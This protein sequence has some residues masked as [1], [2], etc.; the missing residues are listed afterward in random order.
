LE[1]MKE[2]SG[3]TNALKNRAGKIVEAI[4]GGA[5]P[6][7]GFDIDGMRKDCR[8][9]LGV[10]RAMGIEL[11]VLARAAECYEEAGRAGWAGRDAST[12]A[13]YRLARSKAGVTP[14]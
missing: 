12:I 3:G 14:R 8:T 9:M 7:I 4:R 6:E 1:V 10:A 2:S 5:K 11:P 13:A